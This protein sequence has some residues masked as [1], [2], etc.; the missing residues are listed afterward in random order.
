MT[1]SDAILERIERLEREVAAQ[2]RRAGAWRV[3]AVAAVLALV[4][5]PLT[6]D[7]AKKVTSL[8]LLSTDGRAEARF[9]AEGF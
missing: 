9:T 2:R 1:G 5:F 7:A 4:A 8:E 3:A 6:T